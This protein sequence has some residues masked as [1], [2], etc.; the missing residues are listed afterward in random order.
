MQDLDEFKDIIT[1]VSKDKDDENKKISKIVPWV[2]KYRPSKLD[3]VIYQNEIKKMLKKTLETG[4]LP[5]TLFYGPSGTGKTSVIL[6]IAKEL[7]GPKLFN[8]RVI[9]LNASDERGI[10]VVRTKIINFAKSSVGGYDKK[11]LCP[12]YKIIILDEADAMTT[13]AQS[14]LRKI[15]ED[16]SN[17][18]RFCFICNYINK[19]IQPIISRCV[20]FRFKP[21][22]KKSIQNKLLNIS[23]NENLQITDDGLEKIIEISNGDLRKAIMTLQNI[24]YVDKKSLI[25]DDVIIDITGCIPYSVIQNIDSICITNTNTKTFH[26]MYLTKN[27][28]NDGY[29]I[30]NI[31][32]ALNKL[33]IYHKKLSDIM[34]S[35]IVL[36]IS[37]TEKRLLEGSDEYLQLLSVLVCINHISLNE[38]YNY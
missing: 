3:Q 9:E 24:S 21:L 1:Y 32:Y 14:A 27:I 18:T 19:I 10:N 30:K 29:A 13:E 17:I 34:K 6:A 16:Y 33:I 26:L 20:T 15:I 2:D 37:K 7:Y 35:K 4:D 28:I 36:H 12:P 31:L 25:N 8:K 5:H 11:Y 38:K 23:K 22:D